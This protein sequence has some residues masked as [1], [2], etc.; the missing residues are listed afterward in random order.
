MSKEREAA[1]RLKRIYAGKELSQVIY[2]IEVGEGRQEIHK[3]A[4]EIKKRMIIDERLLV[5]AYIELDDSRLVE[6]LGALVRRLCRWIFVH[7]SRENDVA[8]KAMDYLKRNNLEGVILREA[9]AVQA[10]RNGED[11]KS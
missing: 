7:D 9:S 1:G 8:L 5:K 4:N 3:A 6:N 11:G 10:E 2:G